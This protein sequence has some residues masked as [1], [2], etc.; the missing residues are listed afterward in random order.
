M[1]IFYA[2]G[3]PNPGQSGGRTTKRAK[4]EAE[5]NKKCRK[6]LLIQKKIQKILVF[7]FTY[8]RKNDKI[9]FERRQVLTGEFCKRQGG[10]R[11]TAPSGKSIDNP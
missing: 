7:S 8:R 6:S 5:K 4:G 9:C 2:G 3:A 10:E 11:G 1:S